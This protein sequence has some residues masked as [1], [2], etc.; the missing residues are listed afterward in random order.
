MK[1]N[2]RVRLTVEFLGSRV[3]RGRCDRL[4]NHGR[5]AG[6]RERCH[7]FAGEHDCDGRGVAGSHSDVWA[8]FWRTLE[9]RRYARRCAGTRYWVDRRGGL[10]VCA[11]RRR[12]CRSDHRASDVWAAVV[13]L[14]F[15]CPPRVG[16][17][18]E[19][20]RGNVWTVVGDLGM[21]ATASGGRALRGR[22]LYHRCVLVHSVD[23]VRESSGYNCPVA[24]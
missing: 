12:S 2:L 19:R 15:T 17:G 9:S 6:W 5:T 7:R 20:V 13:F 16:A 18:F 23:L 3:P 1:F 10:H 24:V 4:W 21:F 8:D 11:M 14:V 22:E